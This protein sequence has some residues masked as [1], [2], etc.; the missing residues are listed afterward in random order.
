[1]RARHGR[2]RC[3][4]PDGLARELRELAC[5]IDN[6]AK[7]F[8]HREAC[9]NA[10]LRPWRRAT[11]PF[12]EDFTMIHGMQPMNN[13][14]GMGDLAF[15]APVA[16]NPDAGLAN[17]GGIPL[18]RVAN[19]R[20]LGLMHPWTV[21]ESQASPVPRGASN[22][23]RNDL[24]LA[25]ALDASSDES[26]ADTALTA[27]AD[28]DVVDVPDSFETSLAAPAYAA[29]RVA[30]PVLCPSALQTLHVCAGL[31]NATPRGTS[32]ESGQ[33]PVAMPDG[34]SERAQICRDIV[35][36]S[37][38]GTDG[39]NGTVSFEAGRD[40]VTRTVADTARRWTG[41]PALSGKKEWSK[42]CMEYE[43]PN[44]FIGKLNTR[45][46]EGTRLLPT[47]QSTEWMIRVGFADGLPMHQ[48]LVRRDLPLT[49]GMGTEEWARLALGIEQLGERH[50]EMRH[51]QVMDAAVIPATNTRA[52]T[53]L[54]TSMSS[55]PAHIA[56]Q[57]LRN[58][59]TQRG[60][61]TAP[62]QTTSESPDR[63]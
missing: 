50:W 51:T 24:R 1:M 26:F 15:L 20:P 44:V 16:L 23:L 58:Q 9:L 40:D 53:A 39:R 48:A 33:H 34:R 56:T 54:A 11:I 55:V 18:V 22:N 10:V 28:M 8:G 25:S 13:L 57:R 4:L 31:Q 30:Q 7:P 35:Y 41:K 2:V 29:P 42:A 61:P 49:I 43:T 5:G 19:V 47:T 14:P 6:P 32:F 12:S 38:L 36:G 27:L 45:L 37:L 52:F 62:A 60:L 3:A 21:R 46:H 63:Q 59:L 17:A